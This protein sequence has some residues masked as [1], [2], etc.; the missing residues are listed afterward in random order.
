MKTCRSTGDELSLPYSDCFDLYT[1]RK[2]H[3]LAWILITMQPISSHQE[4]HANG[5]M[6]GSGLHNLRKIFMTPLHWNGPTL[7]HARPTTIR[8]HSYRTGVGI[9]QVKHS[10]SLVGSIDA[11]SHDPTQS[12]CLYR[13]TCEFCVH[14]ILVQRVSV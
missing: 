12:E 6:T 9:V 4:L 7:Y 14:S 11:E 8:D 2:L 5:D 10:Q 3:H 1:R 13:V